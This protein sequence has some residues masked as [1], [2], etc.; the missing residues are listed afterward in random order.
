MRVSNLKIGARLGLGFGLILFLVA[1]MSASGMMRLASIGNSAEHL[2][3]NLLVKERHAH[4]WLLGTKSNA[5]RA[6]A[7]VRSTDP[8]S[9]KYFQAQMDQQSKLISEV[10]KKVE[11]TLESAEEKQLF[12]EVGAKRSTYVEKRKS[13]LKLKEGGNEADVKKMLDD[14]MVP[15]LNAYVLS[16]ENVLSYYQKSIDLAAKSVDADYQSGST[17]LLL[18]GIGA[19]VVGSL[20]AWYLTRS[21]T[22]PLTRAL[23]LAEQVAQGDL[24]KQQVD[25]VTHDE[26]GRL[27]T[28]LETMRVSL[29]STVRQI[30]IGTDSIATA[31]S[32]IAAGNLDLS[33]RTEKQ[34]GSLEE[35]AS[36]MEQLTSTVKQNA[37]NAREANQLAAAASGV[38]ERGGAVVAQVVS[39]MGSINDSSRKIVDIIGVIDGIAFQT[40]ILALNAAVEAA[41]AGEQGR[42]FAVVA[43]EVRNLAQRS[44]SAAKEIKSLI[45][46]SVEKVATG[47]RLVS[48]AG[49]TM[50]EVVESVRKVTHIMAEITVASQEQSTGIAQVND[51]VVLMDQVT[52]QNAALVEQAAAAAESLQDQAA[53]LAKL[54][55]VFRLDAAA[56]VTATPASTQL[57]LSA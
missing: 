1:L 24:S 12:A 54:A 40:N 11:A 13:V 7:F 21:I 53:T 10:Q 55:S 52:Q 14:E 3:G 26:L 57:V 15:A 9:Q 8:D 36:A 35:T 2:V 31:S 4:E 47:G 41:R 6:L 33:S 29:A 38:A 20:L 27:L 22:H 44:A 19:F 34:A 50:D 56:A 23:S 17:V 37:E 5:L 48:D 42:G 25:V 51:A 39:T 16:I 49:T 32:Q 45:G 18:G 30:R 46:D 28:A 43:A